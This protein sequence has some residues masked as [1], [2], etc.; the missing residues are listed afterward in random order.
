MTEQDPKDVFADMNVSKI[1]VS[2]LESIGSIAI[3]TASFVSATNEDKELQVDYDADAQTFV[4]KLKDKDAESD[5][6]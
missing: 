3:P 6:Q 5:Q 4:F 2:I 1:L